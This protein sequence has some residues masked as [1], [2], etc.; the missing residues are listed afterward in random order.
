M[1]IFLRDL[2]KMPCFKGS[3]LVA[4]TIENRD[5]VVNGITIIERPDIANWIKG[6]ELLLTSFYSIDKDIEV[7]KNMVENLS[8]KGAAALII[9]TSGFLTEIPMEVISLANHLDFPII[10][11]SGD[12]KYI[13]IMYPVMGEIFNDQVNRLNYYKECHERFTALS[14]ELKGIPQVAK[15]LEE[16][17]ANPVIIFD[18]EFKPI[19][20]ENGLNADFQVIRDKDFKIDAKKTW[21]HNV[22]VIE[23][24]NLYMAVLA[25]IH[26]LNNIKAYLCVV[27]KNTTL[28]ELDYIAVESAATTL[29]LEMLKDVAITEV[30]LKYEGDL[31]QDLIK[32]KFDSVENIH[33]RSK[34]FGWNLKRRFIVVILTISDY[35]IYLKKGKNHSDTQH[36]LRN[37]VKKIMDRVS[38]YYTT[39]YISVNKGDMTVILWPVD[40]K[41]KLR[42]AYTN[43]KKYGNEVKKI[44]GEELSGISVSL[45]IGGIAEEPMEIKRSYLEAKDAVNFGKRIFGTNSIT[46]FD[47]L[48]IYKLLCSYGDREELKKFIHPALLKLQEY[49]K[50]RNND[51]INTLEMYMGCNLNAVKTAEELFVH[52]KTVIYRLNRIKEIISLD[53]ENRGNMLEIEI[54]LKILR[55]LS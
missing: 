15:T 30:Q 34:L 29:S 9:K 36:S 23:N 22:N 28:G 24:E 27:E 19:F 2:I 6:G 55:V 52:Y 31:M 45:G 42:D 47:E 3:K 17:V 35:K 46:A 50:D 16:L 41:Q 39:D 48:G 1:G 33:D 21:V 18:S 26:V 5:I 53:I 51:L 12:I 8:K 7:Q 11:I 44:I 40:D 13:D 49:D 20:T 32:G 54:G 38:Y 10:E 4:G 43:I 14:L 37:K 25:P